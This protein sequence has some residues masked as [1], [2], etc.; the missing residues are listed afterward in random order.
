MSTRNYI[1]PESVIEFE[2]LC[3]K[4]CD[5][6]STWLEVELGEEKKN[7]TLKKCKYQVEKNLNSKRNVL[8]AFYPLIFIL[9]ILFSSFTLS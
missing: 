9:L 7:S 8:D 3:C 1:V 4:A 2:P 5:I 6:L